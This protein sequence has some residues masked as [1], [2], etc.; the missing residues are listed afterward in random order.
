M[1]KVPENKALRAELQGESLDKLARR[2]GKLNPRPHNKTDFEDPVRLI[3]A[4]EI[5]EYTLA[6]GDEEK[7][8]PPLLNPLI[9]GLRWKRATLRERITKRLQARLSA[10]MIEEVRLLHDRGICSWEKMEFFGLEYRYV[11]LYLQGRLPYQDMFEQLNTKIHQFAKRQETWFRRMERQGV[12]IR[13]LED[14]DYGL[15]QRQVRWLG[16]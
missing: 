10:G 11:G 12:A 7:T 8:R 2:L 3:R 13:W 5:A 16:A 14:P 4:I 15:L 1:V 6:H 9:L